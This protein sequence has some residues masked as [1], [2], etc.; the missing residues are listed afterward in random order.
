M[1]FGAIQCKP[2]APACAVCVVKEYCLA[3]KNNKVNELPVKAGK[4]K[5][6]EEYWYYWLI[7]Y[8][9]ELLFRH[10]SNKGIWKNM[11]DFVCIE[12]TNKLTLNEIY[13]EQQKQH[14]FLQKKLKDINLIE[15]KVHLLS[16]RKLNISFISANLTTKVSLP[17]NYV[18]KNRVTYKKLPLPK[19]IAD[20]L[21]YKKEW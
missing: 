12:S 14:L 11:Y 16:H 18:F 10:R 17:D 13:N 19:V 8:K 9:N 21:K 6:K 15:Q 20:F 7:Q 2:Q 3:L 5:L 4:T 1:E